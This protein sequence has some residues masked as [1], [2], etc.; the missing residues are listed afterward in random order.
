MD[1]IRH[2]LHAQKQKAVG[3]NLLRAQEATKMKFGF[4]LE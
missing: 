4:M 3:A 1:E 2:A